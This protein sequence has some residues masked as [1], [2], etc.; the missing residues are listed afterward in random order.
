MKNYI[1]TLLLLFFFV[2]PVFSQ[3]GEWIGVSKIVSL[4]NKLVNY[5][6]KNELSG[7]DTSYIGVPKYK[8]TLFLNTYPSQ[9][10]FDL[11]SNPEANKDINMSGPGRVT[12]DIYSR[13][14]KQVSLGLYYMGYGLSYSQDLNKG[15]KKNL[16]FT[17][18]SSPVGGELLYNTTD[19]IHGKL[20]AKAHGYD[21][22][23]QDGEAKMESFI[24]NA[25]Y[26]FNPKKFSYSSAMSYFKIQKKSAGSFLG[27]V[28]Y[29]QTKL[30]A[31]DQVLR[32]MMGG[33]NKIFLRQ[34]SLG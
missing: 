8:W 25:Y 28:T 18:Y 34:F 20:T 21:F 19:R 2:T 31:Y 30:T 23:I 17:M 26:V 4:K 33:I 10:D 15:F 27:G 11:R 13:V 16:S 29:N 24:I 14:E 5:L 12:V 32:S 9:S 7:V 22:T 1:L 6:E 3:D